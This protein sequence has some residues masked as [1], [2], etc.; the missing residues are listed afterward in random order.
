MNRFHMLNSTMNG[1]VRIIHQ[2]GCH[3]Q[4][5]EERTGVGIFKTFSQLD[6]RKMYDKDP[7]GLQLFQLCN[8]R[9]S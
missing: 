4:T 3:L 5:K 1:H 8:T 2:E 9:A 6:T 7:F